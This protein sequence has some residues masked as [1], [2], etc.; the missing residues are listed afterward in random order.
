MIDVYNKS[1]HRISLDNNLN[2]N[3]NVLQMCAVQS[4]LYTK[5]LWGCYNSFGIKISKLILSLQMLFPIKIKSLD[6]EFVTVRV[7]NPSYDV[8]EFV[9]ELKGIYYFKFNGIIVIDRFINI[10]FPL[11]KLPKLSKC[12]TVC[13][14]GIQKILISQFVRSQEVKVSNNYIGLST[15]NNNYLHI[16]M[17]GFK[18]SIEY[19][20]RVSNYISLMSILDVKIFCIF[21]NFACMKKIVYYKNK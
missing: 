21:K 2:T 10:E 18:S 19:F 13:I 3:N 7:L 8:S 20:E 1:M 16:K 11:F 15:L 17:D 14:G 6:L 5:P 4:R 12:G 9:F